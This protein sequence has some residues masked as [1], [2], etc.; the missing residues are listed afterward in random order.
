M[1]SRRCVSASTSPG[2][3][4][5]PARPQVT[6]AERGRAD[7]GASAIPRW[8]RS[9]GGLPCGHGVWVEDNQD[10]F[11]VDP[12]GDEPVAFFG[13]IKRRSSLLKEAFCGRG[14]PRLDTAETHERPGLGKAGDG[15]ERCEPAPLAVEEWP[16]VIA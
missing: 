7:V 16:V 13:R 3:L 1:P 6:G 9:G 2:S 15:A 5:E 8:R 11:A 12:V 10:P 4:A 14:P